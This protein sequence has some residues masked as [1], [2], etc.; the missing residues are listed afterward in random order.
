MQTHTVSWH[1]EGE[2]KLSG[3]LEAMCVPRPAVQSIF[4]YIISERTSKGLPGVAWELLHEAPAQTESEA[5][6]CCK[7]QLIRMT[8][9]PNEGPYV[10]AIM[11]RGSCA[12]AV[13]EALVQLCL[14]PLRT[15]EA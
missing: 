8:K 10:K 14:S 15:P 2:E 7:A 12:G 5:L 6:Q 4:P 3:L 1:L 9:S 13:M 11:E